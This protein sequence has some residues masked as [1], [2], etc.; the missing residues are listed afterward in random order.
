MVKLALTVSQHLRVLLQAQLQ[1]TIDCDSCSASGHVWVETRMRFFGPYL[2]VYKWQSREE[3][4]ALLY[5]ANDVVV[6]PLNQ[7]CKHVCWQIPCTKEAA[8][9]DSQLRSRERFSVS[10]LLRNVP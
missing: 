8:F 9:I 5:S 2:L 1:P 10:D 4:Q 3:R 7:T 6:V